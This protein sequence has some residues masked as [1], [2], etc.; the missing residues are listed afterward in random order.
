MSDMLD[1]LADL[2]ANNNREWYHEHKRELQKASREFEKLIEELSL[3]IGQFDSGI[4]YHNPKDLTFRLARDTRFSKDKTPY[5]PSFRACMAPAG[6]K[7]IPVGYYIAITPGNRS[8]L[9][10]GLHEA[11]FS[12]ATT[13]VR[14]YIVSHGNELA[15][16]INC[17]DFSSL[18][19]L[20]GAALKN[21]PRGYD[22]EHPQAEYLK[23]KSWFMQVPIADSLIN[24]ADFI[25][26]A[27]QIFKA[28]QPMNDYLNDA[29]KGIQLARRKQ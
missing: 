17:K 25:E 16:I 19:T 11:T 2:E 10:G 18:L 27:S 22:A 12:E 28:M 15:T 21:V 23:F 5:N 1:Y 4:G 6:K 9:G 8:F 13:M 29:L 20:Q 24:S 14:E 7:P 26:E 3:S